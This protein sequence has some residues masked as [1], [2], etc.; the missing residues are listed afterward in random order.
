MKHYS[1]A[2]DKFAREKR[3]DDAQKINVSINHE[4]ETSNYDFE[5][6]LIIGIK[7]GSYED[8]GDICECVIQGEAFGKLDNDHSRHLAHG[9]KDILRSAK[10]RLVKKFLIG[11]RRDD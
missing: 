1:D 8:D 4:G 7:S 5:T 10:L 3:R 11:R 9:I 2:M 6:L